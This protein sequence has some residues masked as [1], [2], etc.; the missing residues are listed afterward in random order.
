MPKFKKQI[1][2]VALTAGLTQMAAALAALHPSPLQPVQGDLLFG[3]RSPLYA[4]NSELQEQA[5]AR[6]RAQQPPL[7]EQKQRSADRR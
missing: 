6:S 4:Q 2:T 1:K 5:A 3:P 7:K